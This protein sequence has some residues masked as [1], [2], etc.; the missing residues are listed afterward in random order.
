M[1]ILGT[2]LTR[3]SSKKQLR[4]ILILILIYSIT[5]ILA[6][7]LTEYTASEI[8]EAGFGTGLLERALHLTVSTLRAVCAELTAHTLLSREVLRTCSYKTCDPVPGNPGQGGKHS[9]GG[10]GQRS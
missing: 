1:Q 5:E 8:G 9:S 10:R 7:T 6:T 4:T 2:P 3:K